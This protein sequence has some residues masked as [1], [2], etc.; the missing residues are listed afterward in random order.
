MKCPAPLPPRLLLES[1]CFSDGS[2]WWDQLSQ[3]IFSIV[4]HRNQHL[5]KIVAPQFG[6][7]F[8]AMSDG[9][10][11]GGV[12]DRLFVAPNRVA[13][14]DQQIE[15]LHGFSRGVQPL[16]HSRQP[17]WT[18]ATNLHGQ[19]SCMEAHLHVHQLSLVADTSVS[20]PLLKCPLQV[21]DK[22]CRGLCRL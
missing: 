19:L 7:H 4:E 1:C 16:N 3:H 5:F 12:M 9:F 6:C 17:Q 18:T 21:F 10:G 13:I 14:L 20:K 15:D 8:I 11:E 2:F 22:L